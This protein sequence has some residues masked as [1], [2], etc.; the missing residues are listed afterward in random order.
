MATN[1]AELPN[2]TVRTDSE[3]LAYRDTGGDGLPLVLLHHFRGNL[4]NWDPALIDE[5]AS[6]RRVITF[7]NFGVGGSTGPVGRTIAEMAVGAIT[8]LDTMKLEKVDLLGFS[9]GSFVAQE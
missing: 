2:L 6:G 5:L 8:F 3:T 9:I 1:Y 4:D 7:D